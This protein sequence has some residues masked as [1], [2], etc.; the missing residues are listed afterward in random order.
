L[1]PTQPPV[2]RVRGLSRGRDADPSPPS[3]AAVKYKVELYFYPA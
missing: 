3:S 2:Q 1:R